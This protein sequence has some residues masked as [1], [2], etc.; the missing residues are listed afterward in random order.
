MSENNEANSA[1]KRLRTESSVSLC[2][3]GLFSRTQELTSSYKAAQPFHHSRITPFCSPTLLEGV[4]QEMLKL[5]YTLKETD[6]FKY[7]QSGDL[8]NMDGLSAKEREQLPC[9]Q[10]LRDALY[11]Q[12]FRDF[13]S[14]VTGCGPLSGIR[15]DMS[16]NRYKQG[17]HLLLHDDVIGDRRVSYIIYLPDPQSQWLPEDGGG[18]ELYPRES[19]E[20]WAPAI[21][22][23]QVI[24]PK[25]NQMVLFTVLPGQSHHAVQEVCG[26]DKERLSIQ[27]WFHF[28]QPGEPGYHA[29]QLQTL[30]QKGAQSTLS[31]VEA[32]KQRE[33][34]CPSTQPLQPLKPSIDKT[35]IDSTLARHINPEY[36]NPKVM[37]Q[38]SDR[39]ADDSYIKLSEFLN[40]ECAQKLQQVLTRTDKE[41]GVGGCRMP[42]Y[43]TGERA[44][45]KPEGSPVVRRFLRVE[46]PAQDEAACLL[47]QLQDMFGSDEFACWLAH[48]TTLSPR[49]CR[50][51]A[52]RFRAG[53]DYTL[54]TPDGA[55]ESMLDAVLCLADRPSMWADGS[56]GG[57]HCYVDGGSDNASNDG[58]VYR[59]NEDDGILLTT[60]AAWNMLTL[61]LREPGV[62]QFVKY[63]GTA[64]PGSRWDI[65][66][67]YSIADE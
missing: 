27:G 43:E 49:A 60:P 45:W 56:V 55:T 20:S 7:H 17:D 66:F 4:R 8:A 41:D 19:Q 61:V 24:A 64:A 5:H 63:V 16:T 42:G 67:E 44:G 1:N 23:T 28:P 40:H 14:Q 29:D 22:P 58:S 62:V 46:V 9:L 51:L 59:S 12:E 52:R 25:W 39:F 47:A 10:Q 26:K 15:T 2:F 48:V 6:I 13:V 21:R 38:I 33:Q 37:Q 32:K 57:Y 31:Q 65:S 34:G 36:L 18:L 3:P 53:L 50:G 30:W 35:L 11:S 54:G